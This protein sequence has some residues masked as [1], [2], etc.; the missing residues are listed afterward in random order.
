MLLAILTYAWAQNQ[1]TEP[2]P[3]EQQEQLQQREN[4]SNLVGRLATDLYQASVA[5]KT[6]CMKA[7]GNIEF[8]DCIANKSPTGI[9]FIGYVSIVAG[10]KEDFKYDQLSPDD[11]KLFDATRAARD[12][13]VKWK[14]KDDTLKPATH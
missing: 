13:C 2:L 10:T 7:F 3:L 8:C 9:D 14:G 1:T 12:A 5:K 4:F 11:K 6:Q